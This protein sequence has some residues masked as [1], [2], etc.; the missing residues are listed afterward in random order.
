MAGLNISELTAKDFAELLS[1]PMVHVYVGKTKRR[2][3]IHKNILCHHSTYFQETLCDEDKY[4]GK[5]EG[6]G[7]RLDLPENDPGAFELLVK[8]LYQGT[9][10]DVSDMPME[11]KWDYVVCCQG[12]YVLCDKVNIPQLRNIAIDQYRKG[13]NEAGLVP[14]PEEI[15]PI[16]ESTPPDSPFRRL[17]IRIAA[18]QIM[19]PENDRDASS[20]KCC[21][22][23]DPDFA[24]DLV[25]AIREGAGGSIFADPTEGDY[26][27]YHEHENGQTCD[28]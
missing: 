16:Y 18:R 1:G 5:G 3:S 26:C 12:L 21:F 25:N 19:S 22:E 2:W 13:C 17:V 10:D 11:R 15:K 4:K 9:I 28:A 24:I 20:Y 27:S 14:D 8:W 23:A 6:D 7:Q